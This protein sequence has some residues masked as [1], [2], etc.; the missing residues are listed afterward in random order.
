MAIEQRITFAEHASKPAALDCLP[1]RTFV[2][3]DL[4]VLFVCW[5]ETRHTSFCWSIGISGVDEGF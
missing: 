4:L 3:L 5:F 1:N 2:R